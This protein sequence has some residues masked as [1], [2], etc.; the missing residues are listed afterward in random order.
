MRLAGLVA[1][2]CQL[3]ALGEQL[4]IQRVQGRDHYAPLAVRTRALQGVRLAASG[5]AERHHGAVHAIH[6]TLHLRRI[7]RGGRTLSEE[8][9][10]ALEAWAALRYL[11]RPHSRT[12]P[13]PPL[14]RAIPCI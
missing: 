11:V 10:E 7:P 12:R 1:S 13:L 5:R 9:I 2:L 3:L 8:G 6:H 4:V 14:G